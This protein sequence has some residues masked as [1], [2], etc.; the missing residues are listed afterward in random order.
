M[1]EK[2]LHPFWQLSS[3]PDLLFVVCFMIWQYT[4]SWTNITNQL[5]AWANVCTTCK[6]LNIRQYKY[7]FSVNIW[8]FFSMNILTLIAIFYLSLTIYIYTSTHLPLCFRTCSSSRVR[9]GHSP[10]RAGSSAAQGLPYT[11]D[12][13]WLKVSNIP[14]IIK[15]AQGLP[16]TYYYQGRLHS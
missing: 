1:I 13:Q 11:W 6:F 15:M 14:E 7:N 12:Y 8:T 10:P 4:S 16:Y 3:C 2:S 5:E 9:W